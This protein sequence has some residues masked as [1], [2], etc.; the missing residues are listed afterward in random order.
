MNQ[1]RLMRVIWAALLFSM[2]IYAVICFIVAQPTGV[3]FAQH[4]HDSSIVILYVMTVV[5]FVLGNFAPVFQRNALPRVRMIVSLAIFESCAIYGLMAAFLHHDYR[6]YLA[7]WAIAVIG[8]LRMFPTAE[9][10]IDSG[11]GNESW[12]T[13]VR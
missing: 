5:S 10:A 11:Y 7:P 6:L 13:R 2:V 1:L 9:S 12:R 4:F 8:F 3:P